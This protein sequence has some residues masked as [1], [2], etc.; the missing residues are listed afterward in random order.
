MIALHP[1]SAEAHFF[2][3]VIAE[4]LS[5]WERAVDEYRKSIYLDDACAL[6]DFNLA[7]IYHRMGQV[8]HALREY[9]NTLRKVK[10]LPDEEIIKFSGGFSA[11]LLVQ[12]CQKKVQ[13][14]EETHETGKPINGFAETKDRSH[15]RR[16]AKA[17]N[18]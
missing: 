3:G 6:A 13:E 4:K 8:G 16:S 18:R 10:L 15:P 1:L 5:D 17:Q 11:G 14:L 7:R 12:I 2:M 9:N